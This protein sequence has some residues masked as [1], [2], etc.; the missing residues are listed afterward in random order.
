MFFTIFLPNFNYVFKKK[1][2]VYNKRPLICHRIHEESTTTEIIGD[3]KRTVE[4]FDI[5]CKFWPK[6]IAKII[7]KAYSKSEKSNDI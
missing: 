4:D 1:S 6:C 3:S 2:F 7:A 5:F